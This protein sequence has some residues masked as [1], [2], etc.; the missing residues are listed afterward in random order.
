MCRIEMVILGDAG[1]MDNRWSDADTW[2]IMEVYHRW[3]ALTTIHPCSHI[4]QLLL[5]IN[6]IGP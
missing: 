3:F 5:T 2:L 1:A 6:I 4:L